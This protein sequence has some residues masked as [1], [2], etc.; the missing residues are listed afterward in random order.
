MLLFQMLDFLLFPGQERQMISQKSKAGEGSFM[1]LLEVK[2][3]KKERK[4]DQCA[5]FP[6]VTSF[7]TFH[8]SRSFV[9]VCVLMRFI[10]QL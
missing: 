2:V 6:H 5:Y 10:L 8:R 7:M 3:K 1:V 4:R 9:T